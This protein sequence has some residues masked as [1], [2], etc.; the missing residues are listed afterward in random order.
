[1]AS[2]TIS[3]K[4]HYQPSLRKR[5]SGAWCLFKV[6]PPFT[7]ETLQVLLGWLPPVALAVFLAFRCSPKTGEMLAVMAR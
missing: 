4:Q 6:L 7:I 5:L 3:A 2:D 1:L